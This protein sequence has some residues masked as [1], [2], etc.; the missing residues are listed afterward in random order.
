MYP[1]TI[2]L[3]VFSVMFFTDYRVDDLAIPTVDTRHRNSITS[4]GGGDVTGFRQITE[5]HHLFF[6]Q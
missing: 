3:S 5:E 6:R 1:K 2:T 4:V